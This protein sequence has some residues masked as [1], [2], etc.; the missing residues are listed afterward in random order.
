MFKSLTYYLCFKN[1]R[2][3]FDDL[4]DKI[5][6]QICEEIFMCYEI[7]IVEIDSDDDCVRFLIQSVQSLLRIMIVQTIKSIIVKSI[8]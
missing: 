2:V 5:L 1:K 7:N 4:V 8:L 3:I 6:F